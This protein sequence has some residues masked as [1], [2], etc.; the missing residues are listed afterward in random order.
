VQ[1][2]AA[3]LPPAREGRRGAAGRRRAVLSRSLAAAFVLLAAAAGA[4][5]LDWPAL[6]ARIVRQ[7]APQ[8]GEISLGDN[9]ELGGA[10][11]GDY[12]RWD[13]FTD[14]T[15]RVGGETW[16]EAGRLGR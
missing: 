11:R 4:Q 6:A 12:V 7:L 15:V 2:P 13:F 14:A 8:P 3:L 10:V 1:F 9:S 16:V 5:D